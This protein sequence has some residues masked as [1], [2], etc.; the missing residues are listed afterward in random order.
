VATRILSIVG[1]KN[2]GKTSL[3][4]ALASEFTRRGKR[5]MTIKHASHPASLDTPGTDT[6]RHFHEGRA[7]RVLIASPDI[8]SVIER[9]PDDTDSIT[10]A[11][12]YLADADLVLVEGFKAEP[13]PKVEVFRR[14]VADR[15]IYDVSAPDA[16][17]WI[18]IVTDDGHLEAECPV[19][20]FK[21]TIWL[22]LLA[23]L[24]WEKALTI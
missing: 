23:G 5:V 14:A 24:A 3:V 4:V 6:F 1:R 12:R 11:R 19:L 13:L 15:P 7:E 9:T 21:D 22:Q 20:R 18:A 17:R 16:D 10:L 2:A 8:R